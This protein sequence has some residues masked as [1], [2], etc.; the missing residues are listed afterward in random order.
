MVKYGVLFEVRTEFLNN[1]DK[2]STAQF[3]YGD[4]PM[5]MEAADSSQTLIMTYTQG[6]LEWE[7]RWPFGPGLKFKRD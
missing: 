1:S 6:L 7:P 4:R 5:R 2:N 3:G